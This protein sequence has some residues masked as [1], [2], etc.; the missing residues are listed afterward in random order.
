MEI[1][2]VK[3][4]GG[5]LVPAFDTDVERLEKFKTGEVYPV[6]VRLA[7]NPDFHKKVFKFFQF[8]F[9]HWAADKT[10]ERFKPTAAQFDTFRKNLT[11]LAGYKEVTF[12]IDGRLRVDAKSLAF[13][14]MDQAEFE[15]CYSALINAAI[16]HVFGG[17]TDQKILDKLTGFF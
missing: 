4:P 10:D 1:Q 6:E 14:N 5:V 11:V 16:A 7:R 17:T 2:M 12:T 13:N 8:C 15:E 9:E 3:Q